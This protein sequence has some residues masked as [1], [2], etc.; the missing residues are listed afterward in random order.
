MANSP[1]LEDYKKIYI[2]V[3]FQSVS[4]YTIYTN[5]KIVR[6][7]LVN[8]KFTQS[9]SLNMLIKYMYIRVHQIALM[10]LNKYTHATCCNF[11]L[12]Y[13]EVPDDTVFVLDEKS[14]IPNDGY[15]VELR[16]A[17]RHCWG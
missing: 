13:S 15:M 16:L 11:N 7:N 10:L 5:H 2:T 4:Y 6:N 17:W 8:V 9:Y 3:E 14:V 1:E 12:I